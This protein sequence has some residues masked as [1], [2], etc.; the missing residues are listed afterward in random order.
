MN[1]KDKIRKGL[2]FG[3]IILLV[4]ISFVPN[5]DANKE[6][7][8]NVSSTEDNLEGSS[9]INSE[10]GLADRSYGSVV[11]YWRFNEGMGNTTHD[12]TENNNNGTDHFAYVQR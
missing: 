8:N 5:I 4:G 1:K 10:K 2:S 12:E 6:K 7:I 3:I 9:M 11:G